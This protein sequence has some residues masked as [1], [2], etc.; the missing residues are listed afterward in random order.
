MKDNDFDFND[1]D[2]DM[3]D[4]ELEEDFGSGFDDADFDTGF[5]NGFENET[6][7]EE[8]TNQNID[9]TSD[10]DDAF[11]S[12]MDIKKTATFAIIIG[13]VGFIIV[14]FI[15][16]A[17][18]IAKNNNKKISN[19]NNNEQS[20]NEGNGERVSLNDDNSNITDDNNS[21]S[22]DK[23][24][25]SNNSRDIDNSQQFEDYIE[26]EDG[27]DIE[28]VSENEGTFTITG[29]KNY[30]K[31][32][33]DLGTVAIISRLKGSISGISGT[34]DLEIPYSKGIKLKVGNVFSIKYKLGKKGEK[35][36]IYDIDYK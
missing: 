14:A 5:E 27:G 20:N 7:T 25:N 35:Q 13:L 33:D 10:N 23:D 15:L 22:L 21:E 11:R 29:I 8:E 12:K 30:A 36:I 18:N 4:N 19:V 24:D 6:N 17:N 9:N 3:F 34:F 1:D 31:V 2:F 26:F 32:A 28:L 16:R